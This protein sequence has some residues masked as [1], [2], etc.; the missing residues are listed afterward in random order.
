MHGK[1]SGSNKLT[2][3]FLKT[4]MRRETKNMK[5]NSDTEVTTSGRRMERFLLLGMEEEDTHQKC[6]GRG[7][8]ALR[9]R[10]L[11]VYHTLGL[12]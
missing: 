12:N 4:M 5:L 11:R 1:S 10:D 2:A 6:R 9:R 7:S 8:A 3:V